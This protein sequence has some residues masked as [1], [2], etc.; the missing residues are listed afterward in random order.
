MYKFVKR[1]IATSWSAY[2]LINDVQMFITLVKGSNYGHAMDE[3]KVGSY[4]IKKGRRIGWRIFKELTEE[5]IKGLQAL[6][7]NPECDM[8]TITPYRKDKE[9]WIKKAEEILS[10]LQNDPPSREMHSA[11]LTIEE[12]SEKELN[13][14]RKAI[15][16]QLKL[17]RKEK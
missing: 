8:L 13:M 14:L 4:A 7:L 17:K 15:N 16:A 1:R 2:G 11:L 10:Y 9:F 12:A 3:H 5:E 6:A